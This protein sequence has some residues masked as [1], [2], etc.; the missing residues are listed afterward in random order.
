MKYINH[1]IVCFLILSGVTAS[2]LAHSDP[3]QL[4]KDDDGLISRTEF[5]LPE[6]SQFI[7]SDL[8]RDGEISQEEVLLA[9]KKADRRDGRLKAK[10]RDRAQ[11]RF[12]EIDV[13]GDDT[14]TIEEIE[15][16]AFSMLDKNGDGYVSLK[17]MRKQKGSRKYRKDYQESAF[18]KGGRSYK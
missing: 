7:R 8:N 11:K 10:R 2:S 18:E 9:Q 3:R 12:T 15:D 17:E 4:D 16:H 5:Q 6:D 1:R 13:N 14:I